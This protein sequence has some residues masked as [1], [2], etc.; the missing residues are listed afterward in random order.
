MK[1]IK[2]FFEE[3][4]NELKRVVWPSKEK[5]ASNTRVVL[6]STLI[7]SI[8]FGGVDFLLTQGIFWIF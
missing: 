6:V 1:K 8:F 3:M 5:V 7:L 4:I 2:A